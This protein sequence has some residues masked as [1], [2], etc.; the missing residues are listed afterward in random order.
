MFGVKPPAIYKIVNKLTW[1]NI[2][3]DH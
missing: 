1:K 3:T 2:W